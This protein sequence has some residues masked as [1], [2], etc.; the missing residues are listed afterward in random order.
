MKKYIFDVDCLIRDGESFFSLY[1][2]DL[3]IIADDLFGAYENCYN[4]VHNFLNRAIVSDYFF[5]VKRM[6]CDNFE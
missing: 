1:F 5:I 3:T 2:K 4:Y 6:E